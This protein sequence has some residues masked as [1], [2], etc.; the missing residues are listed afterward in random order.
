MSGKIAMSLTN[1]LN[2]VGRL[3]DSPGEDNPRER[4]RSFLR[5]NVREVGQV[6]DYIEECLRLTGDQYNYALQDLINH[7]GGLLGFKVMFGRYRGVPGEIG[8]DGH[9]IS[10]SGFHIVIE[11]KTTEAY[12][13]KTS[14]LVGYVDD[15]ISEKEISDW[16]N[17]LGLYVVGRPDPELRQLENAIVGEKRINQLRTISVESLLSLAELMNEY[18]VN[19][20]DILAVL[21]PSG[22][23]IDSVVDL[24]TRLVAQAP[25]EE[26]VIVEEPV[27]KEEILIEA[28]E[29]ANYWLT[30]VKSNEFRT[31]E[32]TIN[33][34]V[35]Q[36]NIYAFGERTPGRKHLKPGD[37]ICFYATGKG[38]I[39]HAQVL[40]RPEKKIHPKVIQSEKYPWTFRVG[41]E[42][43]YLDNPIVIDAD[44]R[45][46][47]EP[48]KGRDP[49]K[50]WSW[51]VQATRK[52]S[53][54][55]YKLLTHPPKKR[56]N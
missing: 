44:T 39:A 45:S 7:L 4:F 18:D 20:D 23:K 11:V 55:D 3:D 35:H 48:F 37:W 16:D 17:T 19:H 2:L 8:F 52:I 40:S 25:L 5:E 56:A 32:E 30:P 6:R 50:P 51:F 28:V 42:K 31:A 10:P 38:V 29:G 13:I 36:E 9:W 46:M 43:L 53:A 54:H 34:L 33:L 21:R 27:E 14:T 1:I 47:L 26:E 22:P 41:H 15:L 49:N 12:A 24:M